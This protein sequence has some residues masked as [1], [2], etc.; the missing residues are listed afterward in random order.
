MIYL[1]GD[2]ASSQTGTGEVTGQTT[3]TFHFKEED[4]SGD[5][6]IYEQ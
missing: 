5:E 1:Y 3:F 2:D 4:N 6:N